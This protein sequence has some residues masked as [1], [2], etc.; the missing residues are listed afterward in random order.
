M[1]QPIVFNQ[2]TTAAADQAKANAKAQAWLNS[3]RG[4]ATR[5]DS[6]HADATQLLALGGKF[7]SLNGVYER[8]TALAEEQG[9]YG[10]GRKFDLFTPEGLVYGDAVHTAATSDD[11]D[12][13]RTSAQLDKLRELQVRR[14]IEITSDLRTDSVT[15]DKYYKFLSYDFRPYDP[16]FVPEPEI[17]LAGSA[18]RFKTVRKNRLYVGEGYMYLIDSFGTQI[19][20]ALG[21]TSELDTVYNRIHASGVVRLYEAELRK[22]SASQEG[23]DFMFHAQT[24]TAG[25]QAIFWTVFQKVK[26]YFQ[27]QAPKSD[28][29]SK[30]A[31][32]RTRK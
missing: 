7:I 30:P 11:L 10:I 15:G 27:Y 1:A 12:V 25:Q 19:P 21:V 31:T 28:T 9:D 18:G 16:T 26:E 22:F 23:E 3:V 24:D 32:T 4:I 29:G 2:Q 14:V 13:A 6:L 20:V 8:A 5:Q 17:S